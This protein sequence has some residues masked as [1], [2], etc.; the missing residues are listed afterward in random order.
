MSK[1]GLSAD[2]K[3][4]R[5]ETRAA[6]MWLVHLSVQAQV[7]VLR[8]SRRY[9]AYACSLCSCHCY[10]FPVLPVDCSMLEY[11]HETKLVFQLKGE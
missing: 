5:Y 1:R 3:R 8:Q 6:I 7:A 2:E 9:H 11:F 4:K 10:A